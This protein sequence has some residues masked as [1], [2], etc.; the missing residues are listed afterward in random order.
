M[1]WVTA[2]ILPARSPTLCTVHLTGPEMV[3]DLGRTERM[4]ELTPAEAVATASRRSRWAGRQ[5]S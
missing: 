3:A 4:G 2:L 1:A 5:G